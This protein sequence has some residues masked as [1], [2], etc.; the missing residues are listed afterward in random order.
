MHHQHA[1]LTSSGTYSPPR[2]RFRRLV[3]HESASRYAKDVVELFKCALLR[4]W[5][6]EEDHDES[7]DVEAGVEAECT[8]RRHGGQDGWEGYGQHGSPE[9]TCRDCPSHAD[10]SVRER[11]DFGGVG[12]GYCDGD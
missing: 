9:E 10:F 1:T 12:E 2:K 11:E 6:E 4:F 7:N 5:N 3:L 8:S